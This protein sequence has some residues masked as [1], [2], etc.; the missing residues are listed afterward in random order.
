AVSAGWSGYLVGGL[1]DLGIHLPDALTHATFD[2]K[3]PGIVNLPALLIIG[4][5][6]ALLYVGA[7]MSAVFNAVVV[8]IKLG[9]IFVFIAV[10]VF[11]V[12]PH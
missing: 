12:Q 9:A 11:H 3:M 6:G 2:P 8:S 1:N 5:L 10:A 4:A 7:K